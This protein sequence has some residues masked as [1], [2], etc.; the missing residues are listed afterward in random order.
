MWL[1]GENLDAPYSLAARMLQKLTGTA[2]TRTQLIP[3]VE[4]RPIRFQAAVA[5]VEASGSTLAVPGIPEIPADLQ[6]G[7]R[8][9]MT[10]LESMP[11]TPET[12]KK[13]TARKWFYDSLQRRSGESIVNWMTRFRLA[14]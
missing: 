7:V 8:R 11:G 1:E 10:E 2:K 6:S 3:L 14:L 12:V 5:P 9:L 4:L 13:G